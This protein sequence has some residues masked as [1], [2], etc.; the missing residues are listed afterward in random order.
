MSIIIPGTII[1]CFC[2]C[3]RFAGGPCWCHLGLPPWPSAC[4]CTM[5]GMWD[6]CDCCR[7]HSDSQECSA[8]DKQLTRAD[9]R[10]RCGGGCEPSTLCVWLPASPAGERWPCLVGGSPAARQHAPPPPL[11]LS[12]DDR[13]QSSSHAILK[14]VIFL[15]LVYVIFYAIYT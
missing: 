11:T 8:A 2:L 4:V 9:S 3:S 7:H 14:T 1:C 12:S 6:G 10:A 13:S 5:S 15:N